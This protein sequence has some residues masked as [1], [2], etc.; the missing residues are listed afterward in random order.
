[1]SHTAVFLNGT[2]S[3]LMSPVF[4]NDPVNSQMSL[5]PVFLNDTVNSRMSRSP[6]LPN[7]TVY[8]T[9]SQSSVFLNGLFIYFLYE[10]HK[11]L[12]NTVWF[13]SAAGSLLY[14]F[15]PLVVL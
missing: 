4:L 11:L 6:V 5:S 14:F 1:M 10:Y 8:S 9:M 3:S 7:D 12:Y 13:S 15:K 2:V